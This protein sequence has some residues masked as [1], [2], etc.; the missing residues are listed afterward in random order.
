MAETSWDEL[1]APVA[2]RFHAPRRGGCPEPATGYACGSAGGVRGG[3]LLVLW[4]RTEAGRIADA[5]F[6][7]FG[8][9]AAI[10][11]GEWLCEWLPGKTPEQA[12][13]LN[14]LVLAERLQLRPA[15]RGVALL[16]EDALKA[17]LADGE[18]IR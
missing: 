15:E 18:R 9:P 6:E 14:G 4:L 3:T 8:G 17:A 7:A 13:E 5:R 2:Q 12:R 1:P 16:A 11:C 10:A